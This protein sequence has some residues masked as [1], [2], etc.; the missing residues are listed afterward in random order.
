MRDADRILVIAE[1]R[2]TGNGTHDE[3]LVTC[4]SYATLVRH[5]LAGALPV[6]APERAA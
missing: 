5:Q 4:S 2:V 3:L 1:G 6:G